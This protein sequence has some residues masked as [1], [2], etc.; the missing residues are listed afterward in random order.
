[1]TTFPRDPEEGDRLECP[2]CGASG[3]VMKILRGR[4][5]FSWRNDGF[6]GEDNHY[7]WSRD[8]FCGFCKAKAKQVR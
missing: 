1:M 5:Y 6:Q 8:A 3:R 4:I 2:A 7:P